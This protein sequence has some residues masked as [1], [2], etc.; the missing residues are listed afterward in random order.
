V[1][2]EPPHPLRRGAQTP[3]RPPL[4][5]LL[6]K[7]ILPIFGE[8]RLIDITPEDVDDWYDQLLPESP[9]RRSHTYALLSSIMRTAASGRRRLITANPCQVERPFVVARKFEPDPATPEEVAIIVEEMP[10]KYRALI[11]IAAWCGLRWGEVSELRRKDLDVKAMTIRV[12]RAVIWQ[13]GKPVVTSLKS[14][15]GIRTVAI[16][17]NLKKAL[18]HHLEEDA[19]EGPNGLLF[20]NAA[21]TGH[22]HINT[23]SKTFHKARVLAGRPELRFHDLRHGSATMAAQSGATLAE[24]M[25]R[26]GRSTPKA[27]LVYQHVA[28]SRDRSIAERMAR[29]AEPAKPKAKR[30]AGP[31]KSR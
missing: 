15:A 6:D 13:Y 2:A 8:W 26:L 14:R 29:L 31:A 16:P 18:K 7:H 5:G 3:H 11:L 12:D 30:R 4:Q 17:P 10:D 28:A 20:P 24:L 27:S 1:A 23:V 21:R 9:T 19:M 22:L 25:A